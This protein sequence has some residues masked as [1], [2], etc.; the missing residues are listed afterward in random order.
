MSVLH[1]GVAHI[2]EFCLARS[3]FA[4]KTAVGIA[5]TRMRIVLAL[6]A[7]KVRTVVI[8]ASVFGAEALLSGPGFDQRPID[9]KML[10]RQ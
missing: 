6:L 10:V 5:G 9:G 8:T 7:M 1:D 2:G 4:V 3:G